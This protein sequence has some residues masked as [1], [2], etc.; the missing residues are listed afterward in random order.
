MDKKLNVT[1]QLIC[2]VMFIHT[3]LWKNVFFFFPLKKLLGIPWWSSGYRILLP[4][5]GT[6]VQSLVREL[7]SH[8]PCGQKKKKRIESNF[9]KKLLA[10]MIH[11]IK[12]FLAAPQ[13]MWDLGVPP[14]PNPRDQV[15]YSRSPGKLSSCM[16]LFFDL[17]L[18][19][20][21]FL[22]FLGTQVSPCSRVKD[23]QTHKPVCDTVFL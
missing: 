19:I 5:E 8:K 10:L 11:F 4:L 7:G 1:H 22:V 23:K 16:Q 2:W 21:R 6:Q 20:I 15:P 13:G 17:T 18:L 3:W 9:L 12:T 14:L